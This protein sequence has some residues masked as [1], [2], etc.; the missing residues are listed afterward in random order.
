MSV[1]SKE[2]IAVLIVFVK[3][4]H[5]SESEMVYFTIIIISNRET[6]DWSDLEDVILELGNFKNIKFN[7]SFGDVR[8]IF[9]P[10]KMVS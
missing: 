1:T 8:P 9:F 10:T 2:L 7:Y 5:S 6:S 4:L 3:L